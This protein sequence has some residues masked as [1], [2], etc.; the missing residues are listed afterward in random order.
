[1]K[2]GLVHMTTIKIIHIYMINL[3]KLSSLSPVTGSGYTA[4]TTSEPSHRPSC[5][6]LLHIIVHYHN[7][8][9]SYIKQI[10]LYKLLMKDGIKF[11]SGLFL[12]NNFGLFYCFYT[13][14][15][16]FLSCLSSYTWSFS[17]KIKQKEFLGMDRLCR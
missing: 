8:N 1:M 7:G 17:M 3:G 9:C 4:L 12:I 6:P 16:T 15:K 11:L 5:S 14:F 2:Q 13:P 10:D